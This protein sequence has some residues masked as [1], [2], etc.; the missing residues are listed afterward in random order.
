[1]SFLDIIDKYETFDMA[2]RLKDASPDRIKTI[3]KKDTLGI[4]DFLMLLSPCASRFIEAM[5]ER[6]RQIT[7]QNFGRTV[8]LYTPLYV[9]DF[10]DNGCIYC[11]YNIN[12]KFK[13]RKLDLQEVEKEARHISKT[14]LKNI[15]LLTGGSRSVSPVSYIKDC[16][17]VLAKY[18]NVSIEVYTLDE[19]EYKELID[20][21]VDGLTVYQETYNRQAYAMAH[22][23]GPK[24]DYAFRLLAPERALK[25]NIRA[26]NIGALL[27]LY[28]F[29]YDGFFTGIHAKYLQDMFPAAEISVSVPRLRDAVSGYKPSCIVN[30]ADIAQLIFALRMFLPRVGINLS[31]RE[32]ACFR[33]NMLGLGI[34]KI[35]AESVTSVGGRTADKNTDEILEQF[36]ISDKRSVKDIRSLLGAKGYQPVFKD[37]QRI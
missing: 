2:G 6:S 10:C 31:T 30:N 19:K 20:A 9:S 13:R 34:T 11:G 25:Q 7:V 14:G 21:G 33:D 22:T 4:D 23:S 1:M 3:L 36:A 29:R 12:V 5:A 26:I 28:D 32:K 27:G 16:V 35:S 37:W 17:L 24:K 8:Q 15:L 18:F